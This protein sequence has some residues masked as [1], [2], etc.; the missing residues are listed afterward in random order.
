MKKIILLAFLMVGVTVLAQVRNR[1]PQRN[2]MEQFTPEQRNQLMLKK[3][4]LELDLNDSQQKDI[5]GIIV[6][7]NSKREAH[8]KAMMETRDKGVKPTRD[9]LFAMR[10]KMLD[11]QIATKRK[12]EKILTPKQFEKWNELKEN[13]MGDFKEMRQNRMMMQ[14]QRRN[15]PPRRG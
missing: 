14:K 4:T 9:E 13:K 3:L 1:R 8:Q 5:N 2:Q 15:L 6:D 12:L 11:E 7:M 10:S